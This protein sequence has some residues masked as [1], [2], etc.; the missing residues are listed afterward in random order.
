MKRLDVA[1]I[2]FSLFILS[3]RA[4]QITNT[5]PAWSQ[6]SVGLASNIIGYYSSA[7]RGTTATANTFFLDGAMSGRKNGA[8]TFNAETNQVTLAPFVHLRPGEWLS[9]HLTRG[10]LSA[11]GAEATPFQWSW[12]NAA[13]GV[14]GKAHIY[15]KRYVIPGSFGICTN[16]EMGDINGDGFLD[17]VGEWN[18]FRWFCLNDGTGGFFPGH[19]YSVSNRQGRCNRLGDLDGDGDLDLVDLNINGTDVGVCINNGSLPFDF[20]ESVCTYTNTFDGLSLAD[21]NGDGSLDLWVGADR[22]SRI[23]TNNGSA[24]FTLSQTIADGA[25]NGMAGILTDLNGD[26]SVD[27]W[28]LSPVDLYTRIWTNNGAGV[29]SAA[30]DFACQWTE[31]RPGDFNNDGKVDVAYANGIYINIATNDGHGA[32]SPFFSTSFATNGPIKFELGDMDGDGDLDLAGIQQDANN[33]WMRVMLNNGTFFSLV[34]TNSCGYDGRL[35]DVDIGDVDGDGTLDVVVSCVQSRGAVFL[36]TYPIWSVLGTNGQAMSHAAPPSVASGTELGVVPI[37]KVITNTFTVS[38]QTVV[39]FAFS[40]ALTDT[41][42]GPGGAS[43]FY[44]QPTST[45]Y[46]A[47]QSSLV[48][49]FSIVYTPVNEGDHWARVRLTDGGTNTFDLFMHATCSGFI[50]TNTQPRN[51]APGAALGVDITAQFSSPLLG[52]S[53]TSNRFLAWGNQSGLHRGSFSFNATS[54]QVT[55]DPASDFRCGETAFAVLPD[56]ITSAAGHPMMPYSWSFRVA[57]TNTACAALFADLGQR[58]GTND[59]RAAALGDLNGDGLLDLFVAN[60][61]D[62]SEVWLNSGTGTL[63]ISGQRIGTNLNSTSVALGDLD[64]D[65]DLDAVLT[66]WQQSNTVWMNNG[67]GTF[68]LNQTLPFTTMGR[69]VVLGDFDNDTD[70]DAFIL[71][72]GETNIVWQ[73]TSGTFGAI[74]SRPGCH[75]GRDAAAGD[76]N[77]DGKTDLLIVNDDFASQVWTNDGAGGFTVSTNVHSEGGVS[78]A[79][80]DLDNDNDLD[81]VIGCTN[82]PTS[83][84]RNDGH[85]GFGTTFANSI[86]GTCGVVQL[87]CLDGDADLELMRLRADGR[88]SSVWLNY[89]GGALQEHTVQMLGV[90]PTPKGVEFGDIDNDGDLDAV[91]VLGTN[92]VR[93]LINTRAG[94]GILATNGT[95]IAS[96]EEASEEKGTHFGTLSEGSV[97]NWFVMTNTS[98]VNMEVQDITTTAVMAV[99]FQLINSPSVVTAH[100]SV[101]FGV[102]YHPIAMGTQTVTFAFGGSWTGGTFQLAMK[103]VYAPPLQVSSTAPHNAE[104]GVAGDAAVTAHFN[105]PVNP[106]TVTTNTFLLWSAFRGKLSGTVTVGESN[107]F[108]AFTPSANFLPGETLFAEVTGGML[109]EDSSHPLPARIWSFTAAAPKGSGLFTT[110]AVSSSWGQYMT[111]CD[112]ALADFDGDGDLDGAVAIDGAT[113]TILQILLNNGSADFVTN[114]QAFPRK[115]ADVEG[116]AAGDLDGDGDLDMIVGDYSLNPYVFWND[117]NAQFTMQTNLFE[118]NGLAWPAIGDLDGDGDQD[119]MLVGEGHRDTVWLNDGTGNFTLSPHYLGKYL[120]NPK[121]ADLD[122]DGDLDVVASANNDYFVETVYVL[123][124]NGQGIFS[125]GAELTYSRTGIIHFGPLI[126]LGDLDA[127]GDVDIAYRGIGAACRTWLND[128]NASFTTSSLPHPANS[129]GFAMGD[130]NADNAL[131]VLIG[132]SAYTPPYP[133]FNDGHAGFSNGAITSNATEVVL[134]ALG[135]LDGNGTLDALNS[136]LELD[137]PPTVLLNRSIA[138]MLLLGTN[139]AAIASGSAA[140]SGKGTRFGHVAAGAGW[141][142]VLSITNGGTESL[143]ISGYGLSDAAFQV[144]GLPDTVAARSV[145][146]LSLIFSPDAAGVCSA[147]LTLTNNADPSPYEVNLAGACYEI[148]TNAG[149]VAGSN[150]VTVSNGY[151]GT[152]TNVL[153]GDAAALLVDSGT[154]WFTITMPS[155]TTNGSVSI[156]IQTSDNGTIT[157]LNAYQY[158]EYPIVVFQDFRLSE[159]DGQIWVSW[160]TASEENTVGF[161]L[162]RWASDAWVLVNG[163]MIPAQGQDGLGASY[164][165]DDAGADATNTFRYEVVA[166]SASG[167][168]EEYGPFDVSAWTPRLENLAVATNGVVIRW[169]SREEDTYEIRKTTNP[170]N[171]YEPLATGLPGA[172]PVNSYTD[173][174]ESAGAAYYQIRVE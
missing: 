19:E 158:E 109:S 163:S 99:Q 124:N 34:E 105:G 104:L 162:Y 53:V 103:G 3:S 16:V 26:G 152:I 33:P 87:G 35:S 44:T 144:S 130:L 88:E 42:G 27:A 39:D 74:L 119:V 80:G 38:N 68:T 48:T 145:S 66:S 7:L 90:L 123:I 108:A 73:N 100:S 112:I 132:N 154:D 61:A 161:D 40:T 78:A 46:T 164:R 157:L 36:N 12:H 72:D 96:G 153:V 64:L 111:P 82:G 4:Q 76:F 131:D 30:G 70:L 18:S 95:A 29:L 55:L 25:T 150:T 129:Y 15:Y 22:T 146:N 67:S 135:D 21:M 156:H 136:G 97:T 20:S 167:T 63:A 60:H 117:G 8:I 159:D 169:L 172:P 14:V 107:L 147:V 9:A 116:L 47:R 17:T 173:Q 125:I 41:N 59:A 151:F 37:G 101:A 102:A 120:F 5:T 142:N 115:Y 71:N 75:A 11:G 127:D 57:I 65:G 166:T 93:V 23:F 174:V 1:V 139:G 51:G 31:C 92:G 54:N 85:G 45:Y 94:M 134:F 171:D 133:V 149:P 137:R 52:S 69:K 49:T 10:I 6:N 32:F 148:S 106:D 83:T 62:G 114:G 79:I 91:M 122:G 81:I 98:P 128:G 118:M 56:E 170:E 126:C 13:S 24:H 141:T 28:R 165:I 160:N 86:P 77:G 113:N 89:G 58:P 168:S 84:Y 138:G 2:A 143:V 43:F 155:A 110:S 140:D 50:V 121:L